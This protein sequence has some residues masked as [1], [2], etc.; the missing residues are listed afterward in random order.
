M[1]KAID[2]RPTRAVARTLCA[3]AAGALLSACGQQDSPMT[4][5]GFV[6]PEG[7]VERGQQVFLD[8]GCRQCH[9]V[10]GLDLPAYDGV[11]SLEIELGGKRAKIKDYGELLTS[12]VHPKHV[13][14]DE[15]L[16]LLNKEE[17]ARGETAMPDFNSRMTVAQLIDLVQFLH[18]R[19]EKLVPEY[20]GYQYYYGP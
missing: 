13:I 3:L 6:L 16:K 17:A 5:D 12:V 8:L 15:Y 11:S 20:R 7:N 10:S 4:A 1:R 14:S 9:V 19:Y 2:S 18:S